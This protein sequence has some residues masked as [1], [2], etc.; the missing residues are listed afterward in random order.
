MLAASA[1]VLHCARNANRKHASGMHLNKFI[2]NLIFCSTSHLV[3]C[4]A[5][6]WLVA[7]PS[8]LLSG[9]L[10]SPTTFAGSLWW[11]SQLLV[12]DMS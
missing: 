4:C 1:F 3:F 10:R 6:S 12:A 9:A 7:R 2:F 8:A 11:L 5:E